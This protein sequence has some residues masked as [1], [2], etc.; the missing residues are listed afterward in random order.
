MLMGVFLSPVPLAYLVPGRFLARNITDMSALDGERQLSKHFSFPEVGIV[1]FRWREK[2][3]VRRSQDLPL[4][5]LQLF[6][7][8]GALLIAFGVGAGCTAPAARP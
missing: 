1:S 8:C 5:T 2:L 6:A 4:F 7:R 3:L